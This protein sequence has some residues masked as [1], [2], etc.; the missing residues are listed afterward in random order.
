MVINNIVILSNA[1]EYS[2]RYTQRNDSTILQLHDIEQAF[3]QLN[4][5]HT[6]DLHAVCDITQ[7]RICV[8]P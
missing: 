8:N 2:I 7:E 4:L 5:S 3:T 6:T 1:H